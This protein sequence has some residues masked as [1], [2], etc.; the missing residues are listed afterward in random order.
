MVEAA[1]AAWPPIPNKTYQLIA[2]D[3]AGFWIFGT[4]T[5]HLMIPNG[6]STGYKKG[7]VFDGI[8]G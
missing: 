1:R 6:Q 7:T 4:G 8:L 3:G 5:E 2:F